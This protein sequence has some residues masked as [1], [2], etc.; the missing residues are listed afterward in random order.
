MTA[1]EAQEMN[2]L[3]RQVETHP[4]QDFLPFGLGEKSSGA[5]TYRRRIGYAN[6]VGVSSDR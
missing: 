1:L 5:S 3:G 2:G 4:V 6:G